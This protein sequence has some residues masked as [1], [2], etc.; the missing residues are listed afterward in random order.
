M[1]GWNHG[2]AKSPNLPV[3]TAVRTSGHRFEP[4]PALDV[5]Q[6]NIE[7]NVKPESFA[8]SPGA[9]STPVDSAPGLFAASSLAPSVHAE[10]PNNID[11]S[12]M[13][14]N[15]AVI[16]PKE[17]RSQ[18]RRGRRANPSRSLQQSFSAA[19]HTDSASQ[20]NP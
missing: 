18:T 20:S 6:K 5:D 11:T 8:F 13:E 15:S 3:R 4:R 12:V 17:H 16:V 9:P 1:D 10:A 19:L 2:S 7:P 14:P